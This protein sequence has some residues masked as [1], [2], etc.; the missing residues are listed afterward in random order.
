M[1][2]LFDSADTASNGRLGRDE[3]HALFEDTEIRYWL[4][5]M[6]CPDLDT[7][8]KVDAIFDIL[9]DDHDGVITKT[10]MVQGIS[11]LKGAARSADLLQL[12]REVQEL[13]R[14]LVG[15]S[16]PQAQVQFGAKASD[17]SKRIVAV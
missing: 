13:R 16:R 15:Q 17:T 5:A 7:P 11:R 2:R 9:D 6:E 14:H 8:K 4:A 1:H 12:I 3:I 10:E